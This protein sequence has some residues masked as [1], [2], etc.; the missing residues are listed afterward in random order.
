MAGGVF[1]EQGVIEQNTAAVDGAGRG[2]QCNLADAV[3]VFIGGKQLGQQLGVLLSAM[4]HDLAVLEGD[5]PALDQLAVVSV[6]LG[7]VD[8]AVNAVA[9]GCAEH[10]LGGDIGDELDA[11]LRLAGRALPGGVLSQTHSQVGAV[12]ARHANT[13]EVQLIHPVAASL[14]A[15][16]MLFPCGYGVT[17]RYAADIK[18]QRPQL[19]NGLLKRQVREHL[20][21]PARGGH[22]GHTPLH[23]VV[24]RVGLPRLH[25]GAAGEVDAVQLA[26]IQPGQRLGVF[27]MDGQRAA[28]VR[29]LGIVEVAAQL[30]GFHGAQVALSGHFHLQA[31]QLVI[32]PADHNGLGTGLIACADTGVGKS[33]IVTGQRTMK[34]WRGRTLT[35][36]LTI[37]SA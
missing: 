26:G 4:L 18:N 24:H 8:A 9:V 33:G 15:G 22:G 21:S 29:V 16:N 20:G 35:P 10:L 11:A 32:L 5:M 17:G 2:H 13:V 34:F 3:G 14:G 37:K 31:G 36:T 27:G 1:V 6:G 30:V 28:A 12:S 19:L 7:A 23:A 25:K